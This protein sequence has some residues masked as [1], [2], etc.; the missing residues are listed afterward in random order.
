MA[1]EIERKF[2][3]RDAGWRAAV[4]RSET[5]RQGYLA[6]TPAVSIRVRVAGDRAWLNFKSATL[7]VARHEFEYAIP[8]AE[9]EEMLALFCAERCLEKTR[10]YVPWGAH[11]W[12]IDEFH[13]ANAGLVVAEIELGAEDEVFEK[14]PWLG[15]EVSDDRRYYNV[16]LIDRPYSRW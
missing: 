4:T 7:G 12:E 8:R 2:L 6:S 15:A 14:P 1:R 13:G 10:H 9:A 11:V 3:L 16:C 5:M